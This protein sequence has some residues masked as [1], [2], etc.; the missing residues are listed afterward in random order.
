MKFS[1]V[2]IMKEQCMQL[3]DIKPD[4]IYADCTAGGGGHSAGILERLSEKGKLV[5]IDKD[6]EA[7]DACRERFKDDARV[8]FI[9]SD[10]KAF[11]DILDR[12]GID[13]VD[14][15]LIDLGISSYQIDNYERGFS[16]MSDDSPLDMRMDRTQSL[17]AAYVLNNYTGKQICDILR[18][19]GE[20]SFAVAIAKEIVSM[21]EKQPFVTCGQLVAVTDKVIPQSVR[22][23]VGHSAKKT[24]Q[25]LRIEVNKELEGL[26]TALHSMVDRLKSGGR[27]AVITFH[28]LEDRIV[29]HCFADCQTDCICPPEFPVCV[30]NH[31]AVGKLV[32]KKPIVPDSSEIKV[33]SRSASA[34]LRALEKL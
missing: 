20:E 33:N 22:R 2:P 16:Y 13:K 21:R 5:C 7:L 6:T 1:H 28:S 34:K 15:I 10:Y 9:H 19:Y 14:G 3:L 27:I 23:K 30:C 11:A 17:D 29:K 18:Y 26:D 24:F 12:L 31:R 4:G 25:A 8:T 32:N